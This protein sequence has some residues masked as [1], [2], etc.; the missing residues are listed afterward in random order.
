MALLPFQL[1]V[2]YI[3]KKRHNQKKIEKK[4]IFMNTSIKN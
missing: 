3:H 4:Y 2:N 1:W